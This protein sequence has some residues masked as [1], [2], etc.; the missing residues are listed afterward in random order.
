MA[1]NDRI[2]VLSH[3]PMY[4]PAAS[5]RTLL[6]DADEAL[7][8]L[9]A[10][11]GTR[12]RHSR[13]MSETLRSRCCRRR[14]AA[15]SSP[16]WPAT[17]TAAATRRTSRASTTSRCSLR[18]T[19]GTRLATSTCARHAPG[20]DRDTPGHVHDSSTS[21]A[22]ARRPPRA[23]RCTGRRVH[24]AHATLPCEGGA[25][26][27]VRIVSARSA[28]MHVWHMDRRLYGSGSGQKAQRLVD[29]V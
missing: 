4:E 26:P 18:S 28:H 27:G 5:A 20:D 16:C 3:L 11:G 14:A 13:D 21:R 10:E 15:E 12:L 17:C 25:L 7:A 1:R 29:W 24:L 9:Q 2:V 22:G 6:Y 23:Y 8:L 19:T